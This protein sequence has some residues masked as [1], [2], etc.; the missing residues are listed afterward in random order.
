[1]INFFKRAYKKLSLQDFRFQVL[2]E[3]RA[4]RAEMARLFDQLFLSNPVLLVEEIKMYLPLFNVDHIQKT[5]YR[6]RNFYEWETLSFLKIHYRQF[7][8]IVEVG[9]NMGNHMLYYCSQ[10]GA[11]KVICFEPN[12]HSFETLQ[13][14]IC[15]NHLEGTVE[16]YPLA[17]GAKNARGTQDHFTITNTGLNRV[18]ATSEKNEEETVEIRSLDSFELPDVDFIKIDVE[19]GEMAVLEGA[20]ETIL[21]C[22]PVLMVEVLDSRSTEV[23]SWL[24]DAGYHR[25]ISL[26]GKNNLYVPYGEMKS[27][28]IQA[29]SGD[30]QLI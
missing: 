4:N 12:P 17:I 23:D 25:L 8:S 28:R 6:T 15:I 22:R 29:D 27:D 18:R 9:A 30:A 7:D 24:Q 21:R 16:A 5:I 1:M 11:R 20:R 19:G 3:Q 2:E 14:N 26:E 13:Q 10:L